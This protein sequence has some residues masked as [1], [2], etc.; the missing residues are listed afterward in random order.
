[1]NRYIPLISRMNVV[2]NI[3]VVM[4]AFG[5]TTKALETYSFMNERISTCFPGHEIL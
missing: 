3:P 4:A 1:M 5:T 2:T